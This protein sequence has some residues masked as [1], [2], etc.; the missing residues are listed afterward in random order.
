[1]STGNAITATGIVTILGIGTWAGAKAILG[2]VA[3]G[4]VQGALAAFP[5]ALGLGVLALGTSTIIYP[6]VRATTNAVT[7]TEEAITTAKIVGAG[8]ALVIAA[9]G[10]FYVSPKCRFTPYPKVCMGV[11]LSS[12]GLSGVMGLYLLGCGSYYVLKTLQKPKKP[13]WFS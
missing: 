2:T 8:F 5:P 7:A 1:M 11:D 3:A 9:C 10:I 13:G 4:A 12:A 6:I